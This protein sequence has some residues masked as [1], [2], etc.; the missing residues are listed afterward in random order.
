MLEIFGMPAI[1]VG[2]LAFVLGAILGSFL[3][4]VALRW[5]SDRGGVPSFRKGGL[6]RISLGSR[7]QCPHC[8]VK[9]AWYELIPVASYLIQGGRCRHCHVPMSPRYLLVEL[10]A[11]LL[12]VTL[13]LV[14]GLSW[15]GLLL[16]IISCVLFISLLVDCEQF[17]LPDSLTVGALG[18]SLMGI[19]FIHPNLS[20]LTDA[21]WWNQP[22]AGASLGALAIGGLYLITKGRGMGLGDV[23]LA[24][25]LGL[26]LG[27]LGELVALSAAFLLGA[28]VGLL[29]IAFGR[30]KLKSAV[31]F[32]PFLIV[33]WWIVLIWGPQLVTWYTELAF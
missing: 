23:K 3:N 17:L 5:N 12:L 9:L 11:G 24:P 7:S 6:G 20:Q 26:M 16:A 28:T 19:V 30:A 4:V 18:L 27:G 29:L 22:L 33:G 1:L 10:A 25:V 31:P 13:F 2:S 32:G 8:H 14:Y 21:V 15:H